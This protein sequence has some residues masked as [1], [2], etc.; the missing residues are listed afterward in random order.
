[1]QAQTHARNDR[2]YL[3]VTNGPTGSGKSGLVNK[4]IDHYGLSTTYTKILI[5]DLVENNEHY[6]S[7]IDRILNEH[8]CDSTECTKLYQRVD[9]VDADLLQKFGEA[10]FSTRKGEYCD[11]NTRTCDE[12][13]DQLLEEAIEGKN[14]IVFETVGT[15]YAQW[16]IDKIKGQYNVIY[17]FTVLDFCEN[18]RRNKTR[19][20][21]QLK[22]YLQDRGSNPAPRLPDVRES[23][24][25]MTARAIGDNLWTLMGRKLF[26]TDF[27]DAIEHII[28]FD[29]TTRKI[30]VLYESSETKTMLDVVAAIE[31]SKGPV[32]PSL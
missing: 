17:A 29:N 8:H 4:V 10:Y 21:S 24:F 9:A 26:D 5:D 20:S 13:N 1:M 28:V 25:E 7:E 12:Y 16:L 3:I 19:A 32:R 2:P 31:D 30:R 15:Y 18:V 6:K 22:A 14:N 11:G 23:N 27:D